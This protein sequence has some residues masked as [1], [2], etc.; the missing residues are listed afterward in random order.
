MTERKIIPIREKQDEKLS[1]CSEAEPY[2][3]MVLGDKAL[4]SAVPVPD[5][6]VERERQ[7]IML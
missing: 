2:A 7:R 1:A 6:D 4:M 5:P 3:L